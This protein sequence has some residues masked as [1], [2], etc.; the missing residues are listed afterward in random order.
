M[1]KQCRLRPLA[2]AYQRNDVRI[3]RILLEAGA[4]VDWRGTFVT[5]L[6]ASVSIGPCCRNAVR[7]LIQHGVDVNLPGGKYG[8]PLHVAAFDNENTEMM[9]LLI[10]AGALINVY[11]HSGQYQ[12]PLETAGCKD[13]E[14]AVEF[15]IVAGADV[16]VHRELRTTL[17]AVALSFRPKIVDFILAA[18]ALK[19]S[20]EE[21]EDLYVM[22]KT[23]IVKHEEAAHERFGKGTTSA[24]DWIVRAPVEMEDTLKV[25][26]TWAHTEPEEEYSR[27]RYIGQEH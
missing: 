27:P 22:L 23:E 6:Y 3:A 1:T 26:H 9:Q 13:R 24:S 12:T 14:K 10:I 11:C 2:V 8:T 4:D 21:W 7:L 18:G 20:R 25:P 19:I 15:L 5:P 16:D 17:L